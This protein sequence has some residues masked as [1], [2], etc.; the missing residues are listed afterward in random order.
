[1]WVDSHCFLEILFLGQQGIGMGILATQDVL[2][3]PEGTQEGHIF[4]CLALS[5]SVMFLRPFPS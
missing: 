2:G 5:W 1:M 3:L 4:I